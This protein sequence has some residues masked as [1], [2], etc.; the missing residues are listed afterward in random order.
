VAEGVLDLGAA[1][2]LIT[3]YEELSGS[4]LNEY[5]VVVVP[6]VKLSG[7]L[8][9]VALDEQF[10]QR[11]EFRLDATRLRPL[12]P[13]EGGGFTA[14]E[15]GS[16]TRQREE[17]NRLG[18]WL[19]ELDV[20]LARRVALVGLEIAVVAAAVLGWRLARELRRGEDAAIKLQYGPLIVTARSADGWA[21]EAVELSAIEDLVR[22]AERSGQ[23][24]V[25]VDEPSGARYFVRDGVSVYSY[26]RRPR[27][28]SGE[29]AQ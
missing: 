9:G 2:E 15:T 18:L 29:A 12:T 28:A 5:V 25:Q 13:A 8:G 14:E 22:V 7:T 16:V 10:A 27:T 6:T 23:S 3:T 24:I 20:Q 11:V 4:R 21:A 19:V 1:Q 17:P 26:S